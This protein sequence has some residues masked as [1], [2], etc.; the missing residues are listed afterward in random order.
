MNNV[1]IIAQ[2]DADQAPSR[3]MSEPIDNTQTTTQTA[4]DPN[5]GPVQETPSTGIPP[6][7]ILLGV[8]FLLMYFVLFR[9]P[10][11]K[12]QQHRQMVQSLQK[13]DRVRTIG[14][15]MGTVMDIKGDEV[16][17]KIDEANNTK[18]RVSTSAIG[19]TLSRDE[20]KE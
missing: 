7:L 19:K 15:I 3:I 11:K 17:L 5:K 6:Q 13:N 20:D 1:W 4:E 2:T 14:G 12:Q 9:G 16:V 18:I 8:M 10:K